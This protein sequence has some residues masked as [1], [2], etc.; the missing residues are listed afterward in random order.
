MRCMLQGP[1]LPAHTASSPVS[2]GSERG[3]L[4][5]PGEHPLDAL[6]P[7][8][9]RGHRVQGVAGNSP[10][11]LNPIGGEVLDNGLGDPLFGVRRRTTR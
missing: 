7:A 11:K 4:L 8:D 10:D 3:F 2:G 1:Q 6:L 5:M 9:G